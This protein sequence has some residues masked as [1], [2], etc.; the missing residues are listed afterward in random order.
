[1]LNYNRLMSF[2]FLCFNN[3]ILAF[4]ASFVRFVV[5]AKLDTHT[6]THT[7]TYDSTPMNE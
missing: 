2:L 6:H 4:T 7:H 1:M 5:L 3:P